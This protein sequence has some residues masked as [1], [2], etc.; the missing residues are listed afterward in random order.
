MELVCHIVFHSYLECIY[1][2]LV[3]QNSHPAFRMASPLDCFAPALH[4]ALADS[5]G[6]G[7]VPGWYSELSSQL[8]QNL[9]ATAVPR[10]SQGQDKCGVKTGLPVNIDY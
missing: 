10:L 5:T 6:N 8:E 2:F 1:L 7:L 3:T 9:K 4:Y